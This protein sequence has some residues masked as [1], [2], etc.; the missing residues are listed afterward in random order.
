MQIIKIEINIMKHLFLLIFFFF[1]LHTLSAMEKLKAQTIVPSSQEDENKMI[2]VH[3]ENDGKVIAKLYWNA[4]KLCH[5]K[6][7]HDQYSDTHFDTLVIPEHVSKDTFRD[8]D[9]LVNHI[10]TTKDSSKLHR[11]LK[12][13][14]RAKSQ[15]ERINILNMADYLHCPILSESSLN[16]VSSLTLQYVKNNQVLRALGILNRIKSPYVLVAL[17]NYMMKSSPYIQNMLQPETYLTRVPPKD[18]LKSNNNDFDTVIARDALARKIE[19]WDPHSQTL[20]T[21]K[22]TSYS[23][24]KAT[25]INQAANLL[26]CTFDN[27]CEVYNLETSELL[28][29][30]PN[31]SRR[32]TLVY[33]PSTNL[34]SCI[35]YDQSLID[36]T[37]W[38]DGTI[39]SLGC[40]R[41]PSPINCFAFDDEALIFY[42]ALQNNSIHKYDI[43]NKTSVPCFANEIRQNPIVSLCLS[44]DK[45]TLFAVTKTKNHINSEL[46]FC[47]LETGLQEKVIALGNTVKDPRKQLK[48]SSDG[49]LLALAHIN[50]VQIFDVQSGKLFTTLKDSSYP[51]YF[52]SDNKRLVARR[53]YD[54]V[55]HSFVNK[56]LE[57]A[58]QN[59]S[60]RHIAVLHAYFINLH[61]S[62]LKLP[63]SAKELFKELPQ[64]AKDFISHGGQHH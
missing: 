5:V 45:K 23:T 58:L 39:N 12:K 37:I 44:N 40:F 56:A 19:F 17:G 52:S 24:I 6:S 7:L 13:F 62:S 35:K 57:K 9:R 38:I 63:R 28:M 61:R 3:L 16:D 8:L 53:N 50:E 33:S 26:L 46:C 31:S 49:T 34:I 32:S 60:A 15:N 27:C 2:A 10:A 64:E 54:I 51:V 25:S 22:T 48:Q 59:L 55:E 41:F 21:I 42:L 14:L 30:R 20:K 1:E 29:R 36:N 43:K 4:Q 11:N 18:A 47:N